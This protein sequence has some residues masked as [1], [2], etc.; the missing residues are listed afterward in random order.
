MAHSVA[1]SQMTIDTI[2]HST[3]KATFDDVMGYLHSIPI[4]FPTKKLLYL[5][6]R[7]EV[8]VEHLRMLKERLKEIAALKEGWD[9]F[10][11]P[12]IL[13]ATIKNV[14]KL[15][16]ACKASELTEWTVSPNTNGTILLERKEAA[17]SIASNKFSYYAEQE[18]RYMEANHCEYTP[19]TLLK[20]LLDINSFLN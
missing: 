19:G 20:A 4:S 17:I 9:G 7:V 6:L 11:A 8:E 10:D 3:S 15:I 16:D 1:Q 5:Q 13:N 12:P 2:P 14:K 18:D